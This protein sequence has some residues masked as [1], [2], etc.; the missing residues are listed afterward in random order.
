MQES[1]I[2]L[3]YGSQYNQLIARRIRELGV[4]SFLLPYDAPWAEMKKLNPRGII[5]SGGPSSVY[6][7]K[8]P[9]LE[10]AVLNSRLPIL[11]ICYG[12]QLMAH[13]LGGEVKRGIRREYGPAT[14]QVQDPSPLFADLPG[15]FLCWMSHGDEVVRIPREFKVLAKTD[16][17]PFA[18]V[19]NPEAGMYGVQFH[20]E[21]SHTQHGK[22]LLKNFLKICGCSF[23]WTP[24][25]F[26]EESVRRIQETVQDG[27]AI[28]AISGGV[29][30]TVAAALTARAIGDRLRAF[31]VDNGLLREGEAQ[32]VKDLLNGKVGIQVKRVEARERFLKRLSGV[33]DPEEKR[34]IIG[35]EFI[36]V[37]EEE[38]GKVGGARFLVQGTLYPDV[39]ESHSRDSKAS[40]R[41]KSHHNVGGLPE[42]MNLSLVEP[43]RLLFKDEVRE[44]GKV[45]GLPQEVLARQPFPG[46][47]LA[48][49]VLGEVNE[50]ALHLVRK[51]DAIVREEVERAVMGASGTGSPIQDL[52]QFF[53]LLLPLRTVG[54]MGDSRTY[55]H[56]VAVRC[57]TSQDGM[58]ADWARLPWDLLS[59]ISSRIVNEVN[60]VNRVVYDI[61]PK[62]PGTIEW[63]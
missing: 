46:P 1:I 35:E 27:M 16:T 14:L 63:E 51:A 31:F 57:V 15:E 39:I 10:D 8:A 50:R 60:G 22:A 62:P 58:T 29:D 7:E 12:M 49:R 28:C 19:G 53:A 25:A 37:F 4:C 36:R 54:V 9:S 48:V 20:P 61:T 45:L 32:L 34:K 44:I 18:A 6:E 42:R 11:G 47:G 41:I 2:I 33:S 13:E 5:L 26:I 17:V 24:A 52:W 59:T 43:L 3:D 40:A 30:S 23:S 21:V 56:V 38:A 55:G